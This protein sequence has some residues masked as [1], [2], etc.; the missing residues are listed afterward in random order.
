MSIFGANRRTISRDAKSVGSSGGSGYGPSGSSSPTGERTTQGYS[1]LLE[2]ASTCQESPLARSQRGNNGTTKTPASRI[3]AAGKLVSSH[4]LLSTHRR[5]LKERWWHHT[6]VLHLV[7]EYIGIHQVFLGRVQDDNQRL[8]HFDRLP[9]IG[10]TAS[11]CKQWSMTASTQPVADFRPL[12][13]TISDQSLYK[14]LSTLRFVRELNLPECRRINFLVE[15]CFDFV[16]RTLQVLNLV[17]CTALTDAAL[18]SITKQMPKLRELYLPACTKLEKVAIATHFVTLPDGTSRSGSLIEVLDI[19]ANSSVTDEV[20]ER[21]M[22]DLCCLKEL[23]LSQLDGLMRPRIQSD[24]LELLNM[25]GCEH[26]SFSTA[27]SIMK[28]CPA[29]KYV[30]LGDNDKMLEEPSKRF[31]PLMNLVELNISATFQDDKTV[32]T[33]LE[34]LPNLRL[35]DCGNSE[36]VRRPRLKHPTLEV[37]VLNM[38]CELEDSCFVGIEQ[39]LPNLRHLSCNHCDSL[40]RPAVTHSTLRLADFSNCTYLCS[41]STALSWLVCPKLRSLYIGHTQYVTDRELETVLEATP[42]LIELN[43]FQA[44]GLTRPDISMLAGVCCFFF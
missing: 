20:V 10:C 24:H 1:K 40:V 13:Y 8:F 22:K 11:V 26:L 27:L 5:A 38:C 41:D 3:F 6:E 31:V 23:F 42:L 15:G 36:F 32:N 14:A 4:P 18:Y 37:L 12:R 29:L 43:L 34:N 16:G 25:D 28:S 44:S 35:F 7:F 39:K 30:T 9:N 2:Y 17:G 19:S 33:A 21:L